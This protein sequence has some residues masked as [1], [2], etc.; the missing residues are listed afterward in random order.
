MQGMFSFVPFF[1]IIIIIM[2]W[3]WDLAVDIPRG[4][5]SLKSLFLWREVWETNLSHNV[6]SRA[7]S[8]LRHPS[9]SRKKQ[10][11]ELI[12]YVTTAITFVLQILTSALMESMTVSTNRQTV[13]IRLDR[14]T[15]FVKMVTRATEKPFARQR[16]SSLAARKL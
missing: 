11:F 10:N 5:P 4:S 1:K 12:V 14:T 3:L 7:L 2:R 16:V 15:V 9:S 6:G 13:L 8:P